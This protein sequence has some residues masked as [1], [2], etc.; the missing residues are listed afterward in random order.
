MNRLRSTSLLLIALATLGGHA[1]TAATPPKGQES[2]SGS[3]EVD[4]GSP[5]RAVGSMKR[6][7][8]PVRSGVSEAGWLDALRH[9]QVTELQAPLITKIVRTYLEQADVWRRTMG[10]ELDTVIAEVRRIREAGGDIPPELTTRVR[11]IRGSMPKWTLTQKRIISELTPTQVESLLLEIDR[12]KARQREARNAEN[13]R[14]ALRN[15][16]KTKT[17]DTAEPGPAGGG[18][19]TVGAAAVV[20]KP[21]APEPWSFIGSEA[22]TP[23]ESA[24]QTDGSTKTDD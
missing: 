21:A 2:V 3:K 23:K 18:G 9:V 19:A 1:V 24:G 22:A 14:R 5:A 17:A 7:V 11:M 15:S 12:H 10:L 13:R 8:D 4:A 20:T 16:G 6:T